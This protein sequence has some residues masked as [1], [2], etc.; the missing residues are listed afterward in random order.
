MAPL[1]VTASAA[2]TLA[3]APRLVALSAALSLVACG[4]APEAQGPVPLSVVPGQGTGQAA[5]TV[6]IAGRD[7]DA[8]TRTDFSSDGPGTVDA[9]FTVALVPDGGGAPVVLADAVLTVRRTL[10]ATVPAGLPRGVYGLR[11]TDVRGRTGVL[12]QAFR[13]VTPGEI[14]AGFRVDVLEPPRA[15]VPFTVTVTA[16]DA[17]GRT[18]DG[19]DG[20]VTLADAT[21][22]LSP[23]SAGPLVLGRIQLQATIPVLA[24]GDRIVATGAGDRTGASEPFDVVAGPPMAMVFPGRSV[25]AAAGRCSPRVDLEL[26]DVLGNP[27]PAEVDVPT[28]LQS[29]RPAV[30]FFSDAACAAQVQGVPVPTGASRASFHFRADAPGAI[31]VR[32]VPSMLPSASQDETVAP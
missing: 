24:A 20:P 32:A 31:T 8:A 3:R 11:V 27:S 22:A 17:Q 15:G 13:V 30:A 10:R 28:Q 9:R 26:R 14:V 12:E 4:R 2:V 7:F 29:S 19:F 21:G 25:A 23:A 16:L 5:V 1:G 6:E 18:A